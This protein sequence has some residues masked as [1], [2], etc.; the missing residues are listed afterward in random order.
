MKANHTIDDWDAFNAAEAE[1]AGADPSSPYLET[2]QD[3][4]GYY[5]LVDR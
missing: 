5:L 1:F 4:N 2:G 3:E